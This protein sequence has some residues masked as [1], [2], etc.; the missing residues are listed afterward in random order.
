MVTLF[1]STIRDAPTS[2]VASASANQRQST[3]NERELR[4]RR[5]ASNRLPGGATNAIAKAAVSQVVVT[6][7]ATIKQGTAKIDAEAPSRREIRR[8]Y[9]QWKAAWRAQDL[10][11]M[12][13][14]YS[15]R[16]EFRGSNFQLNG[17][18]LISY[19]GRRSAFLA[20]WGFGI[21]TVND[22]EPP[23]I[24]IDGRRAVLIVG[25]RYRRMAGNGP[26]RMVTCRY[27]LEK[28][29]ITALTSTGSSMG[30]H[31]SPKWRIVREERLSYQGSSDF[32]SQVY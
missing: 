7:N 29:G 20:V 22:I 18:E 2:N 8:M 21:S 24:N 27:T 26:G 1:W 13:S 9:E 25:Q 6:K 23:N 16:L 5:I 28:E 31:N 12:M 3:V 4:V 10:G 32:D 14:L 19:D 17:S 11:A 30:N 15:R